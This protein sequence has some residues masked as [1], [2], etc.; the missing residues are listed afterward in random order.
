[1]V[2]S[3]NYMAAIMTTTRRTYAHDLEWSTYAHDLEGHKATKY[4][5]KH[6]HCT[7]ENKLVDADTSRFE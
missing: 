4:T 3:G 1:M 6:Q 2:A 5:T 7:Q